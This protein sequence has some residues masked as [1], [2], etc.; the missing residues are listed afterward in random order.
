MKCPDCGLVNPET[1]SHC[2]RCSGTL[3]PEVSTG[4][5]GWRDANSLVIAANT[6][7]PMRCLRCNSASGVRLRKLKIEQ[8]PKR[9]LATYFV[10]YR[11]WN[12]F[13]IYL[14][15]CA[16]HNFSRGAFVAL[17]VLLIFAGM[18]AV[19]AG[20]GYNRVM[21][22][23]IGLFVIIAGFVLTAIKGQPISVQ[24]FNKPLTWLRGISED[25][26]ASLPVWK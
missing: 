12:R 23:Y 4:N 16:L 15:L 13:T 7:L 3:G 25:Y 1:A 14:P 18:G 17:G 8:Y 22:C 10:G 6:S 2:K 5:I 9:N 19:A 26:L 24:K 21:L 11:S 20:F